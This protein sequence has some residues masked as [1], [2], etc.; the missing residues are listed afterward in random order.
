[1]TN[2]SYLQASL[3]RLPD[4][5]RDDVIEICVNPDGSVWGEFQGD[6]FMRPL[7]VAL[8]Q[9][10]IR[11]SNCRGRVFADWERKANRIGQH[12]ISESSDT[13]AGHSTPR[14]PIRPFDFTAF[15]LNPA[16][17]SDRT[18]VSLW[19]RAEFGR[20]APRTKPRA[21]SGRQKR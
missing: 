15:F 9:T 21:S 16:S 10:E 5:K 18:E 12:H 14:R 8:S 3:D 7:D 1:M 17:R 4:A 11:Q 2:A 19:R 6:H 20:S 13:S